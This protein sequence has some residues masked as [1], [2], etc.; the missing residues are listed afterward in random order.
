MTQAVWDAVGR[1]HRPRRRRSSGIA[2]ETSSRCRRPH[3]AIEVPAYV[4]ASMHPGAVAIPI[5][6]RYAP[7]Q[8]GLAT[9]AAP[10]AAA[11]TR[12]PCLPRGGRGGL[13]AATFCRV[14]VTLAKT[15]APSAAG[16][17]AGH[18]RSG[19]PRAGAARRSA[20][21]RG[22]RRCAGK[23]GEHELPTTVSAPAVPRLPLG[24][25]RRRRR[26]H[27]LPGVRGRLPGRRTTCPSSA[28]P[29]PPTGGRCSGCAIERWAE[30]AGRAAATGVPADVLPALRGRAVRARSARCS[31]RTARR[32]GSTGRSTT[33]ASGTRYCGNNCPYHVR[34]FNWY[35]YEFPAPLNVQLNPDVTVRQLG[36]MEKCTMCIQRIVA[37]KR[38]R[39]RREAAGP[40]TATS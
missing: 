7:Y 13:G 15:G 23:P 18:P 37:G 11:R 30:G 22:P 5:G 21:P 6:H 24:H 29:R 35:N 3:G 4:S 32:K 19:R 10:S 31:P 34:R 9:C 28:R 12:W 26:L 40:R 1:D 33:A 20:R 38:P 17:P 2:R 39:A 14:R 36:V 27:R 25:V 16:D 8:L